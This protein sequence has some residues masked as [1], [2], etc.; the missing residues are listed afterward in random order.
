MGRTQHT[1]PLNC[2]S[3][4]PSL[5]MACTEVIFLGKLMAEYT[6]EF[7]ATCGDTVVSSICMINWE[8]NWALSSNAMPIALH[9][10]DNQNWYIDSM[11]CSHRMLLFTRFST[12][13]NELK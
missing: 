9:M 1:Y 7:F 10:M 8:S 5:Q 4:Q 6:G 12:T 3:I 2:P 13:S 11:L